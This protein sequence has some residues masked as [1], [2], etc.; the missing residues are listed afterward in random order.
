MQLVQAVHSHK[1][2]QVIGILGGCTRMLA[3]LV[4]VLPRDQLLQHPL[5]LLLLSSSYL[6]G[7]T[8]SRW[9]VAGSLLRQ[10]ASLQSDADSLSL[11]AG[12]LW[13]AGRSQRGAAV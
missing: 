4:Q 1:L 12:T 5:L 2:L 8:H 11:A 13:E 10:A 6:A 9:E 3:T 7:H